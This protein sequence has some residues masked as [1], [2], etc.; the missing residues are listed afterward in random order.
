VKWLAYD[1]LITRGYLVD[2]T[3][4]PWFRAD[5]GIKDGRIEAI[6]DLQRPTASRRIDAKGLTVTPGFIDMHSHS[7]FYVLLNPYE[8]SKIFQGVTTEVV[9]NCGSSAAPM[10]D[11]LRAYREK[12]MRQRLGPDFEFN[13]SSMSE[14]VER[15]NEKGSSFNVLPLVGH[16]TVRSNVIGFENRKPTDG[17]MGKMRDLVAKSMEEGAWGLSTGL[18]YTPGCYAETDEIVSLA[19]VAARYHG[20]YSSHIRGEGETLL[21]AVAE[22][23]EIGEKAEIPVEISHFKASGRKYWG[24]TEKSLE[25]VE[26]ARARGLDTT[27]DQY[28]YTASS[29]GLSA[30]LPLWVRDG[31]NDMMLER[32][33]GPD[34]REKI[35]GE[36]EMAE[37]EWDQVVV[38]FAEKHPE[39]TGKS[40]GDI[41]EVQ[42]KDLLDTVFDL[43][44]EEEA[45]VSIVAFGM[46]EEDV[47][48]VMK[49]PY[50]MVGT[51][52]SA[53]SPEG[54]LGRGKPHPRFYGTFPRIL[55]HYVREE[56]VL[57]LQKAVRKMTS[58]PA[59]KIGLKD[60]GLLHEGMM[61]DI[62]VFDADEILDQATFTDPHRFPRGIY[63]VIVEGEIVV[64]RN[65]HTGALPGRALKKSDYVR[66]LNR[67][68]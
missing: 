45:S 39:Y 40:I 60:R 48:R 53:V 18:I 8:E 57:T 5:L 68:C 38:A 51:D 64:N 16:G 31:G 54:I 42:G 52:G 67:R 59:Q 3:G 27:I 4:N 44:M 17:E 2:G 33:K 21:R 6:G 36:P 1:L 43:L 34:I 58:L 66:H 62:V 50:M 15:V 63:Y 56:G 61:A 24:M 46:C 47:R 20:I 55:G 35:K 41:A 65:K 37:R 29:T 26:N 22:A 12:Y 7:D 25:L 30:Y 32:L 9:G 11:E 10:N 28:P 13:W 23:I 14:Y 19:R 49:S